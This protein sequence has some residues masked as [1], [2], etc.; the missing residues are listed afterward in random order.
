MSKVRRT[1]ERADRRFARIHPTT[2]FEHWR[3]P[4]QFAQQLGRRVESSQ[5][6]SLLVLLRGT[7][8]VV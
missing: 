2:V 1:S 6:G 4:I 3:M 5:I 7:D 8:R